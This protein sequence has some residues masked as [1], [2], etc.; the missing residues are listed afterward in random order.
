MNRREKYES[1]LGGVYPVH[2]QE[3]SEAFEDAIEEAYDEG[4]DDGTREAAEEFKKDSPFKDNLLARY[5]YLQHGGEWQKQINIEENQY[6]AG[7]RD[8]MEVLGVKL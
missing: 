6:L 5:Y 3:L 1:I 7:F 2:N 8:A 4:Y